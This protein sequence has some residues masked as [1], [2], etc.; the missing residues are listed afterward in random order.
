MRIGFDATAIPINR[1]G[2]GNY[3]F[4][5]VKAFS[6]VDSRHHYFIFAKPPHIAELAI[7]RENFHL[8][9]VSPA[10]PAARLL[11]EQTTLPGEVAKR[12]IDLL[13]SPHYTMPLRRR[14]KSVVTFC[15]TTFQ[16]MPEVHR[17]TKRVFFRAMMK[18]SVQHADCLVAISESTR[19]DVIN[20]MG[21]A[22]GNIVTVPLAA[23]PSYRVL[24]ETV[25][26]EVCN[27]LGLCRTRYIYYVGVLEPRKNVPALLEAYARVAHEFPDVPL[28][29]AGKKGWMFD[30]IFQRV[31]DLNLQDRVRFLGYVDEEELVALYNGARVFAYPSRYEGFGLPVLEAMQCGV[32][33]VTTDVSSMPEVAGDAA[34]LV[35][36][37]DVPALTHALRRLLN[38]DGL[39]RELSQRGLNRSAQFSWDRCARETI[40]VYESVMSE[41]KTKT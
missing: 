6:E 30:A 28:V 3:I 37:D 33:V 9:P 7:N 14:S 19:Q 23:S 5:L 26:Q 13:H 36:P 1:A 39:A 12:R 8:V 20:L 34:L 32:P 27:R 25:V 29:I 40:H 15:D 17:R 31:T 4:N 10:T 2:A 18:W 41:P 11:W 16:R 24:P 21:V 22:P 38:D 35:S